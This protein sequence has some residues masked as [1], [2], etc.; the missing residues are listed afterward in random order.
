MLFAHAHRGS[1]FRG[2]GERRES[3]SGVLLQL[4]NYVMCAGLHGEIGPDHCNPG[5]INSG[6]DTR[7]RFTINRHPCCFDC[8]ILLSSAVTL[9]VWL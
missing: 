9:A 1:N 5:S 6:S 2:G 4:S 8:R 7:D 3:Y